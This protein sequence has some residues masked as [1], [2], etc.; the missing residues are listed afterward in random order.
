MLSLTPLA[1]KSSTNAPIRTAGSAK[2]LSVAVQACVISGH[3]PVSVEYGVRQWTWYGVAGPVI[4]ATTICS[5]GAGLSA[6][7]CVTN[8]AIGVNM[9]FASAGTQSCSV[10]VSV[11]LLLGA[12]RGGLLP[13]HRW[14]NSLQRKFDGGPSVEDS[15]RLAPVSYSV[16]PCGVEQSSSLV[17]MT[18]NR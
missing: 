14:P 7:S 4:A 15:V 11:T 10:T 17:S 16:D 8:V 9:P 5:S 13:L 1:P 12:W 3:G 6:R 2:L 18:M